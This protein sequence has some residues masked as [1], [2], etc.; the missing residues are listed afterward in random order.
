MFFKGSNFYLQITHWYDF[1]QAWTD[2]THFFKVSLENFPQ[3]EHLYG[4]I[5]LETLKFLRSV[6]R[7]PW[8]FI[9]NTKGGSASKIQLF[10]SNASVITFLE[11]IHFEKIQ[12]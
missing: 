8:I 11:W 3:S 1:I 10:L 12:E 7:P 5:N 4:F 2:V 9:T 6:L